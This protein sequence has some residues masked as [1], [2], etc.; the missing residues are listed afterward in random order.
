[1]PHDRNDEDRS[2]E[3]GIMM[4]GRSWNPADQITRVRRSAGAPRWAQETRTPRGDGLPVGLVGLTVA[5]V[6]RLLRGLALLA[7]GVETVL[8]PRR[9]TGDTVAPRQAVAA[10]VS[11]ADTGAPRPA[12]R[13]PGRFTG[14]VAA[15]SASLT[16]G[17][18]AAMTRARQARDAGRQTVTTRAQAT[19]VTAGRLV[20]QSGGARRVALVGLLGGGILAVLLSP[21]RA[22]VWGRV[23]RTWNGTDGADTTGIIQTARQGASRASDRVRRRTPNDTSEVDDATLVDKVESEIFRDPTA[24]KGRININAERGRVVLRGEV[25]QPEQISALEAAVREVPGVKDVENLL[26]LPG[27]SAPQS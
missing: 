19:R 25:D 11:G 9:A 3:G 27:T 14:R 12:P 5:D 4:W 10:T 1:M 18:A 21:L 13:A 8:L 23:R 15:L 16:P 22:W 6:P 20:Q 17:V 2:K 26:H 7:T 24:P